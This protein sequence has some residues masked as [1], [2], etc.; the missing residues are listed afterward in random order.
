MLTHS[1]IIAA[2]T[3]IF[4]LGACAAVAQTVQSVEFS[5]ASAP[6]TAFQ[7][8]RAKA[9]GKTAKTIPGD[10]LNGYLRMPEGA[11]PFPAV[12]LLHGCEG[13]KAFHNDWAA[14][15]TENGF[16]TLLVDSFSPRGQDIPICDRISNERR[17]KLVSGRVFDAFGALQ[18]LSEQ[19]NIDTDQIAALAW[20]R[21]TGISL[22]N[23]DSASRLFEE[24]FAATVQFY[25]ECFSTSAG[26]NFFAPLLM[27]YPGK[28]DWSVKKDCAALAAKS[29]GINPELRI[30]EGAYHGFD[31]PDFAGGTSKDDWQNIY[32]TPPKSVTVRYDPQLADRARREILEFL[33]QSLGR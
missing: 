27:L 1:A 15:L 13:V 26:G 32:K 9:Q 22:V 11:G 4:T 6:P 14:F 25:P 31:D 7:L 30:Y 24:R 8:K 23:Q 12:V 21:E 5:S 28:N 16:A 33:G 2:F 10:P 20:T 18:F 19:P 17:S 3:A 29:T